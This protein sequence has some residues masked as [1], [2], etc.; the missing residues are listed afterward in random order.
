MGNFTI[1]T[2]QKMLRR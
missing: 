2:A 1:W